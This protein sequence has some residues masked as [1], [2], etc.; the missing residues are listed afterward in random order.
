METSSLFLS[1]DRSRNSDFERKYLELEAK[2]DNFIETENTQHSKLDVNKIIRNYQENKI[3]FQNKEVFN[4]LMLEI[5]QVAEQDASKYDNYIKK[6]ITHPSVNLEE[7]RAHAN[8]YNEIKRRLKFQ[9]EI[10]NF[11]KREEL[12]SLN[13]QLSVSV[14]YTKKQIKRYKDIEKEKQPDVLEKLIK[15]V[16]IKEFSKMIQ[17]RL[18]SEKHIKPA[19]PLKQEKK[20]IIK[21]NIYC[22]P[23]ILIKSRASKLNENIQSCKARQP[24]EKRPDYLTPMRIKSNVYEKNNQ[25]SYGS[26]EEEKKWE[27]ILKEG[28]DKS[29]HQ[30]IEKVKQKV[31]DFELKV[32]RDKELI[33][34][35]KGKQKEDL[36]E[37]MT[38]LLVNSIKAKL[39]VLN[40]IKQN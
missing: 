33:K 8:K 10:E 39:A 2:L 17:D 28:S 29:I 23:Q 6:V 21:K 24:L 38:K 16:N 27:S 22:P 18:S 31:K 32:K 19:M 26:F 25:Y 11:N 7:I 40:K 1:L 3:K 34:Y 5:S 20:L 37:D 4:E 9:K 30:S 35:S 13:Q 36:Q 15:K 14:E 12:K